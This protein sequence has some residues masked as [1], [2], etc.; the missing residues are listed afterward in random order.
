MSDDMKRYEEIFK[1]DIGLSDEKLSDETRALIEAAAEQVHIAWAKSRL[2]EGWR[3][4]E[5]R[6]DAEKLT[7]CLVPYQQLS[8]EEKNYDRVTA[9]RTL[10]FLLAQNYQFKKAAK[11]NSNNREA[12]D[13]YYS[14]ILKKTGAQSVYF[15]PDN[16]LDLLKKSAGILCLDKELEDAVIT[17]INAENFGNAYNVY[18]AFFSIFPD[19]EK[20]IGYLGN[21]HEFEEK[22]STLNN[23]QRDHFV[24]SVNV[25]IL[26]LVIYSN[27][28]KMRTL[29]NDSMLN[30]PDEEKSAGFLEMWGVAALM[31]DIGY[32]AEIAHNNIIGYFDRLNADTERSNNDVHPYIEIG[33]FDR[34]N[35]ITVSHKE[36]AVGFGADVYLKPLDLISHRLAEVYGGGDDTRM[37]NSLMKNHINGYFPYMHSAGFTDH[38]FFSAVMVLR[39][40]ACMLRDDKDSEKQGLSESSYRELIIEA[41]TAIFLHNSWRYVHYLQKNETFYKKEYYKSDAYRALPEDK[42]A[43]GEKLS[44]E[45][46]PLGYLMILCDEL[47]DWNRT[48]YGKADKVREKG[49]DLAE[50]ADIKCVNDDD[51]IITYYTKS[52]ADKEAAESFRKN[53]FRSIDTIIDFKSIF[54]N[55]SEENFADTADIIEVY[56][57]PMIGM[58]DEIRANNPDFMDDDVYRSVVS[59]LHEKLDRSAK[60]IFTKYNELNQSKGYSIEHEDWNTVPLTLQLSNIRQ[61]SQVFERLAESGRVIRSGNGTS[62]RFCEE[63]A[64]SEIEKLAASEHDFWSCERAASGWTVCTGEKSTIDKKT[65]CF[66][67][68]EDLSEELKEYDRAAVRNCIDILENVYGLYAVK[69]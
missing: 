49:G 69:K 59:G 61:A 5:Q 67:E 31:H 38:G 37:D 63:G 39:Q 32:P 9:E 12:M 6:N 15:R 62:D 13:A 50:S 57:E 3:Y 28:S 2:E 23:K 52:P 66:L 29:I 36:D 46:F 27:N 1:A 45:Q 24:H 55:A 7:P 56:R 20:L 44:P 17:F 34:F 64:D 41:A 40:F 35:S 18:K 30:I 53:K 65:P 8:E 14:R 4:G 42:K 68:Y 11:D 25:F 58:L 22:A 54:K 16:R 21:M 48:A 43:K 26:G 60:Y 47:Q 10:R 19:S 33:Y 51:L